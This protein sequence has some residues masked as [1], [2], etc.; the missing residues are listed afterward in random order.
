MLNIGAVVDTV[1]NSLEAMG[2][3]GLLGLSARNTAERAG[4][5]ASKGAL[6]EAKELGRSSLRADYKAI[7]EEVAKGM[8]LADG[9]RMVGPLDPRAGE[10]A[11]RAARERYR[12]G[13]RGAVKESR[14]A[15]SSI[16]TEAYD[17]SYRLTKNRNRAAIVLGGLGISNSRNK[18]HNNQSTFAARG[19]RNGGIGRSSGA[20]QRHDY[21]NRASGAYA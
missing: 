13:Y 19:M 9:S 20:M 6:R 8:T 5:S 14:S 17:A 2:E 7:E 1:K 12:G 3:H 15:T 11:K 16:K 18:T 4:V 21:G 10:G